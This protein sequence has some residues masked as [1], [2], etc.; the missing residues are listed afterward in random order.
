ML[1]ACGHADETLAIAGNPFATNLAS[2]RFEAAPGSGD[3]LRPWTIRGEGSYRY[4]VQASTNLLDCEP[5]AGVV[6]TPAS[7]ARPLS[8]NTP[9]DGPARF[10][11]AVSPP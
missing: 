4:W 9:A 1:F 6:R 7:G 5:V 3:K 8:D 10:Y 2:L 11:R